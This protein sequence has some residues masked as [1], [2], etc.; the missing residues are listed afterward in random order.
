M[1]GAE[2]PGPEAYVSIRR[3]AMGLNA[4]PQVAF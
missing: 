2:A 4:T 3:K 1:Q